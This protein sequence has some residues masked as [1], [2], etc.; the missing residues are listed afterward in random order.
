MWDV[1][2]LPIQITD[3]S[4][5]GDE[6]TF[7]ITQNFFNDTISK[8]ALNYKQGP[9]DTACEV[10]S[11]VGFDWRQTYTAVCIGGK[12]SV[13]IYIHFCVEEHDTDC[14]Y[15]APPESLDNYSA[16]SFELDCDEICE[17]PTSV[18][19][20]G[21]TYSALSFELEGPAYGPTRAPTSVPTSAPTSGPTSSST[22][23]SPPSPCIDRSKEKLVAKIGDGP[24]DCAGDGVLMWD[25]DNLPIQITDQ[26]QD[27]DEVTFM[28]T[29]NFFNDTISK[30]ALNY[31]Q[32]PVDTA[33]EVN[34]EVGFDWRQ[35][36]TA[37]CIGGKA[38]VKIYIHFCVEEHDTDCDY[39]APPESLD[40]YSALSFELDCDEICEGPTSGPT[41]AW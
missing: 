34:S 20:S 6:V 30:L 24:E 17:G 9:V 5:D 26:S 4:Q 8:L 36:Y 40:N 33:C 25:V 1:D 22:T 16:L 14:D 10:N 11:E 12:A 19:T 41:S 35:T 15:C 7:M 28:I 37:V 27:G 18:P 2:N 31:K 23:S 39:C 21:P 13:K 29:Q 38:S 3:Q 32:G